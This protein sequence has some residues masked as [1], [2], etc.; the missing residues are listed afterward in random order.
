[1]TRAAS[2]DRAAA[3]AAL[4]VGVLRR[5]RKH[6][7]SLIHE[8]LRDVPSIV[9]D[10]ADEWD[11]TVLR[12]HDAGWTAVLAVC[13]RAGKTYL[14]K[15]TP[16]CERFTRERAA[17]D[18][19]NG[20]PVGSV[21]QACPSHRALLLRAVAGRPGGAG[22]PVDDARRVAERLPELHS[23]GA[24]S[25][26]A[27]VPALLDHHRAEVRPR[28][29]ERLTR[30]P[31]CLD[32]AMLR[33]AL[34]FD[35]EQLMAGMEPVMLHADLYAENITFDEQGQPVFI[36]PH[37]MLGPAAYDWA[38]WCVYYTAEQFNRRLDLC[39]ESAAVPFDEALRHIA[40]L[41]LDGYLYYLDTDDPRAGST[42]AV[43]R[44][45]TELLATGAQV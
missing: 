23:C 18:H 35:A 36:D 1:M 33:T 39:H 8:W 44:I 45:A 28:V 37:P 42:R 43:L 31:H 27:S 10:L 34:A 24:P 11:L 29:R 16:D 13:E 19:W 17:L 12:Y 41:A 22:R 4:P 25:V 9:T 3:L 6:Y 21:V 2:G 30:L 38:F 40:V 32:K 14:L 20:A 15:V 26:G 5:L 7:G